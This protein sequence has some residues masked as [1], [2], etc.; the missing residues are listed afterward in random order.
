METGEINELGLY[1][2]YPVL[3]VRKG[4]DIFFNF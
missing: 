4:E 3:N 2:L 1:Q